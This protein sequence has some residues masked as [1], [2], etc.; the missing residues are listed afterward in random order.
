MNT[1][2]IDLLGFLLLCAGMRLG[3]PRSLRALCTIA[4]I[5]L[6][7]FCI[8]YYLWLKSQFLHF[9]SNPDV[10]H[11]GISAAFA[12]EGFWQVFANMLLL[13]GAV[14]V[15][16]VFLVYFFFRWFISP[17]RHRSSYF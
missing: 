3:Q 6:V 10:F 14:P 4:C 5:Y 12:F 2:L 15:A 7:I 13:Q 9:Q 16:L 1:W 8:G 17:P 11:A